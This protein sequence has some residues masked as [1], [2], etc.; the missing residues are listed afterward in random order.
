MIIEYA[1]LGFLNRMPQ[2]GY[3]LKKHLAGSSSMDW[4][5]GNNQIYEALVKLR[6][7][8]LVDCEENRGTSCPE[9]KVYRITN[10]GLKELKKWICSTPEPPKTINAFLVQLAFADLLENDELSALL[11]KYENEV[12]LQLLMREEKDR[13]KVRDSENAKCGEYLR[14]VIS[15]R[16]TSICENELLWI[17]KMREVLGKNIQEEI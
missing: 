14:N 3:D 13:R 2:T 8:G 9:K 15:D 4:L 7:E 1:L 16:V 17:G 10:N 12:K 5:D 11:E 6:K